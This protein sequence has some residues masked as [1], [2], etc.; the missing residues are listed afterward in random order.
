MTRCLLAITTLL[1][2]V[3]PAVAAAQDVKPTVA[4]APL[5]LRRKPASLSKKDTE[6]ILNE[7]ERLV[8]AAGARIPTPSEVK[9]AV[10]ALEDKDFA[11]SDEVL[12]KLAQKAQTLYAVH[13]QL[14][15]P[16]TGTVVGVGRVVRA[17]GKRM[18]AE[19]RVERSPESRPYQRATT[20]TI[21][22]VLE[23]LDLQRLPNA[24]PVV[25]PAPKPP[26]VAVLVP[27]P[28]EQ[29]VTAVGLPSPARQKTKLAGAIVTGIGAAVLVGGLVLLGSGAADSSRLTPDSNGNLPFEQISLYQGSKG[30]LIFGG[31]ITGLGAAVALTGG[32]VWLFSGNEAGAAVAIV[33]GP[34][35]FSASV[36]GSF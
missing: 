5:E 3:S 16:V 1:L 29:P 8:R 22:A 10:D 25:A 15:Y 26:P 17:D 34:G 35:G 9:L 21:I 20:E 14:D 32:L 19:V 31:G 7:F 4:P 36:T 33:P 2:L 27:T 18:N 6:Q 23:K 24:M 13:L 28:E 30:K 11:G 12:A